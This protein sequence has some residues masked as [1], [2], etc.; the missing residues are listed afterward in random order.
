[1]KVTLFIKHYG[2][3]CYEVV[4]A[5][6]EYAQDGNYEGFE[7]VKRKLCSDPKHEVRLLTVIVPDSA[8]DKLFVVPEVTVKVVES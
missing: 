1:M 6:D 4:N 5:W 8:I 7:E 2:D 3:E